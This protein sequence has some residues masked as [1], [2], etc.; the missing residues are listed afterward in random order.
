MYFVYILQCVD[1]SFYTGCTTNMAE[2][3]KKHNAGKGARYTRGRIPVEVVYIEEAAD[4]SA[5]LKREYAIKQ[6]SRQQKEQLVNGWK[7]ED[8]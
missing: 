5:A 2:R 4:R 6:F 8:A 3:L 7:N 1:G